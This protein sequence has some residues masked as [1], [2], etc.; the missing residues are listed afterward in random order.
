MPKHLK[1]GEM[2]FGRYNLFPLLPI[3]WSSN[4]TIRFESCGDTLSNS[5]S[6]LFDGLIRYVA[7]GVNAWNVGALV[8]VGFDVAVFVG[9]YA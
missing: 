5:S 3:V 2:G 7:C 1:D 4:V 6:D 9:F 8:Q